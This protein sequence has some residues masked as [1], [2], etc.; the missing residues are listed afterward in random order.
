MQNPQ[1]QL[2]VKED[3]KKKTTGILRKVCLTCRQIHLT[4]WQHAFDK[5][6]ICFLSRIDQ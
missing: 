6:A 4:K 2:H 5:C 1:Q 3:L